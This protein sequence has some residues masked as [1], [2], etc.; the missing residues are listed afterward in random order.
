[1]YFP[2]TLELLT[3]ICRLLVSMGHNL[4]DRKSSQK[5]QVRKFPDFSVYNQFHILRLFGVLPKFP[6][7][8][9]ETMCDYYL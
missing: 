9:S 5:F 1:M 4:T 8:I 3:S 2:G 7:T 6:L